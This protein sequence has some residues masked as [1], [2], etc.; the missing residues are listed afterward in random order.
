[1]K[2][3]NKSTAYSNWFNDYKAQADIQNNDMPDN[4]PY[5]LDMTKY[6]NDD[7]S[8]SDSDGSS[9]G[10]SSDTNA[11]ASTTEG[12]SDSSDQQSSDSE[13]SAQ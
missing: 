11:D 3:Q 9:D 13:S 12:S 7:S 8:N 2:D 10:S 5:N 1:M 6:N 4:V